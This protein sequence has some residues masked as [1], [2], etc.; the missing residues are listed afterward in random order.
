MLSIIIV[1]VCSSGLADA[2][3]SHPFVNPWKHIEYKGRRVALNNPSN[4]R[5]PKVETP[6]SELGSLTVR[7][8]AGSRPTDINLTGAAL[9]IPANAMLTPAVV[10]VTALPDAGIPALDPGLINVTGQYS[11]YRFLPHGSHFKKPVT[12]TLGYDETKI[13]RGYTAKDVATFFFD[14]KEKHWERLPRATVDEINKKIISTSTHFTDMINGILEVPESPATLATTPNAM[15]GIQYPDATSQIVSIAPPVANSSGSA[16]LTY[17]ISLPAGRNGMQPDLSV[18]YNSSG[19]DGWL[20]LGWDLSTSAFSIETRWGV[21]RYDA[22]LETETY[23]LDGAQLSPVAHR[24]AA[25]GRTGERQFYPRVDNDFQ[26]IIRHGSSPTNYWWEVTDK[27]GTRKFYGGEP[28]NGPD[29]AAILTDDAGH[30]A[31]WALTESRDANDNFVKYRYTKVTDAGTPNGNPGYNLYLASVSYT[32]HGTTEGKYTVLFTRDRDLA[33]TKRKDISISGRLGFKQVTA[34]LLRKIAVQYNGQNVRS[35]ELNYKEG[36]FYKTLLQNVK[37]FDAAGKL[38]ATHSFDYYNDVQSNGV[39]QPLKGPE[40]WDPKVDNVKGTFLNPI[41]GFQDHA[42]AL[43]GNK[44]IGGGFGLAITIGPDDDDLASKSNTAGIAFGF[45]I[46]TNEG[47]LALVDINGDGLVD[48]VFKQGG[49]LY[50]RANQSAVDSN[51]AF[52]PRLPINGLNDFNQGLSWGVNVG[53]ESNFFIY[54]GLGYAHSE[55]ITNVYLQD[56]NGDGL[57][58]IVNNGTVFFNHLDGAGNPTF[59]TSSGDTPSPIRAGSGIDN[60]LVVNDSAALQKAIDDNPL[61]DVVKVWVAPFDGTVNINAPVALFQDTSA[62]AKSYTA[63]D[64]VRVAIQHKGT[65]LWSSTIS[66]NDF[67]PKAPTG[68]NAVQVQKGDRIYFRVQSIFNG[69][70]DQVHWVPEITYSNHVDGL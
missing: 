58:D 32:G 52:G 30:I 31:Y 43:S 48:K 7:K 22:N 55:D 38:F 64:G 36:A 35:Y 5:K 39:Y 3:A 11:G 70:Y 56:V 8:W 57:V 14:E 61:H 1:C 65:E 27:S 49:N 6:G 28:N 4:T 50:Y 21:P 53:L 13:P 44:S 23:T 51:V 67:T 62:T 45:N 40:N 41:P 68:V 10:S 2:P 63:A 37:Q 29:P 16:A 54:A 15:S 17:A 59:T 9:H 46:S 66:A 26:K 18:Q 69:A 20:G 47:M 19:S 34:D 12:I 60:S 25:V 42:S 24:A 33:E